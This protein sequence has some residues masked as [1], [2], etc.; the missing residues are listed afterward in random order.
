MF[1]LLVILSL[2]NPLPPDPIAPCFG[3]SVESNPNGETYSWTIGWS[4]YA[5]QVSIEVAGEIQIHLEDISG[6]YVI[7]G[8]GTRSMLVSSCPWCSP[9]RT[10]WVYYVELENQV[11]IPLITQ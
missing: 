3:P 4:G 5:C 7:Q 10:L 1:L 2:L 11:F 8:I 9:I 6:D